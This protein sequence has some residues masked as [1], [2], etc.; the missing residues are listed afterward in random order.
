MIKNIKDSSTE[1]GKLLVRLIQAV[2]DKSNEDETQAFELN[3]T[4]KKMVELLQDLREDVGKLR[5]D[6]VDLKQQENYD[7]VLATDIGSL[8][9]DF[10]SRDQAA[11][12]Q[13]LLI[14]S[15][16]TALAVLKF[17]TRLSQPLET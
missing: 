14:F 11:T 2:Q 3:T 8:R 16:L 9:N 17:S 1:N 7:W 5:D 4:M 13:W 10:I 12:G 15:G 6:K